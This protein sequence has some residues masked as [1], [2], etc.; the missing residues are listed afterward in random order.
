MRRFKISRGSWILSAKAMRGHGTCLRS[1]ESAYN[2]TAG[3][4]PYPVFM[5]RYRRLL[6]VLEDLIHMRDQ[7]V[8]SATLKSADDETKIKSCVARINKVLADFHFLLGVEMH[9]I[10][11]QTEA[12]QLVSLSTSTQCMCNELTYL[13]TGRR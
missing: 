9:R 7:G 8:M 3:P 6:N 11:R 10:V 2:A 4:V 13:M 12:L 1:T 5:L